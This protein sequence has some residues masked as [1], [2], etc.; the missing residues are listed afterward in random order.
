VQLCTWERSGLFPLAEDY[1]FSDLSRLKVL[2]DLSARRLSV[3]SIRASIQAMQ[4]VSGMS[5]P[6]LEATAVASG[7]RLVF[8]HSG[9]MVD[10]IRNQFLLDFETSDQPA[11][12]LSLV[13]PDK[14]QGTRDTEL[15]RMF[16][17]AVALEENPAT[18]TMAMEAYNEILALF[19][20]HAPSAINM[21]T[22]LYNQRQFGPAEEFYRRATIMDPKY[23]LAF[24][25]LGN[26]LDELQRL[27]DAI[28]AY[29]RA[30]ALVPAYADA[31]YNLALA[32]ERTGHP[33]RA[34]RHWSCYIK[35]DPVGPWANHARGQQRKVLSSES[36]TIVHRR[37]SFAASFFAE[38]EPAQG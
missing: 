33:R 24:F 25:D 31:H 29:K 12:R 27:P 22:L 28:E 19:P 8:R 37:P 36:L 11:K 18:H 17:A 6:L 15:Q 34:L 13:N 10:P 2:Q 5:N 14:P 7:R 20:N 4:Q 38:P 23:A 21:G 26:V 3:T 1:S 30:V 9:M 16:S 32:Y 35:L